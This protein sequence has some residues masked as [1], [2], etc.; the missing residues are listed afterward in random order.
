MFGLSAAQKEPR[1]SWRARAF[2]RAGFTFVEVM[3]GVS[4]LG[5]A[6]GS[7]IFGLSQLNSFATANRLYT[8]AHTLAQNQID[9]ILTKGPFDPTG[10]KY[11]LLNSGDPETNI[12][13]TDTTYYYDPS[14]PSQLYPATSYP[15]GKTTTMY[16]DPMN[17]NQVVQGTIAVTVKAPSAAFTV[18]GQT[19]NLRQ[20]TVRVSYTFQGHTYSI[21]METMRASDV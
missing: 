11:P 10:N 13:R 14:T 12:L 17:G 6:S 3:M 1:S 2:A 8:T 5:I 18:G 19:L 7:A 15:N 21:V 9:M 4:V 20:A 16:K